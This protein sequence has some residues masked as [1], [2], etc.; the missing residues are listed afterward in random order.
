MI[1]TLGDVVEHNCESGQSYDAGEQRSLF[2]PAPNQRRQMNVRYTW[3]A[4]VQA[5]ADSEFTRGQALQR[6]YH[7]H[8]NRKG[9]EE[10]DPTLKG[11]KKALGHSDP[12]VFD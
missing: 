12:P 8:Q 6:P 4:K 9:D 7:E 11:V 10:Y 1:S 3:Q 5:I 2:A